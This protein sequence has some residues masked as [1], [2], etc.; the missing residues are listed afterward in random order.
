MTYKVTDTGVSMS[1]GRGAAKVVIDVDFSSLDR[2]ARRSAV[3]EKKLWRRGYGRACKG[4]R[5]KLQKVI[6]RA[7]GVEGVPKF[8]NF[9]DFTKTLRARENRTSEPMGGILAQRHVIV[10]YKR[11]DTQYIGWPDKLAKWAINFQDGVGGEWAERYF[12]DKQYRAVMHRRAASDYVP[13]AYVHNPRRVLPEPFGSYVRKHL[14]EWVRGAYYK[15][16][17]QMMQKKAK[18]ESK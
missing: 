4:L 10:A 8:K 5:D 6:T 14:G 16:L 17:A 12:T 3:D 11:G 2:W 13:P 18:Q 1:Q 15:Q 9:E 7:G